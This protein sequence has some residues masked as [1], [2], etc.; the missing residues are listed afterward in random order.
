[1]I[2]FGKVILAAAAFTA[3][4]ITSGTASAAIGGAGKTASV[5]KKSIP[6]ASNITPVRHWRGRCRPVFRWRWTHYGYRRVFVGRRCYR[7][8][9]G[10]RPYRWHRGHR[11]GYGRRV[12]RGY[13]YGYGRPR[14]SIRF[15]F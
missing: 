2:K 10:Y 7:P 14:F 9:Y 13:R 12:Y 6:T 15:G 4:A 5:A 3:I 11:W 8:A 1:M